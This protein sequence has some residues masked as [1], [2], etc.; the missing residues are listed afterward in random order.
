[1]LETAVRAVSMNVSCYQNLCHYLNVMTTH[2]KAP[3]KI[4]YLGITIKNTDIGTGEILE[5]ARVIWVHKLGVKQ[6]AAIQNLA[7]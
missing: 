5:K 6:A 1:M 4:K 2:F 3:S 7:S